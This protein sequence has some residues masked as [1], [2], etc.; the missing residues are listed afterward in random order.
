MYGPA[1]I[2]HRSDGLK[3][4]HSLK[5][6]YMA[7]I[8]LAALMSS[9]SWQ[10]MAQTVTFGAPITVL[11]GETLPEDSPFRDPNI[12]YL[13]ADKI[14]DQRD[15]GI[16]T[17]NGDV[18]ARYQTR[19]LKASELI[20][21][22]AEQRVIAL[23]NVTLTDL[24]GNTQFAEKIELT[25][26]LES[27]AAKGF[28]AQFPEGGVASA[29]YAIRR[30]DGMLSL[31]NA[32]YSPCPICE[33]SDPRDIPTLQVKAAQVTQDTEDQMIHYKDAVIEF[34]GL[35]IFYSPYLAHPDPTSERRSGL[36]FPY[37]GASRRFG[38]FYQQPYYFNLSD[39]SGLTVTPRVM[40]QVNPLVE[41][42]Y[43]RRFFSGD[44][45]LQGSLTYEDWFDGDGNTFGPD[46]VFADLNEDL[47]G[48][49]LRGHIF[50]RGDFALGSTWRWGFGAEEVSDD[51][52]LERYNIDTDDTAYGLFQSGARRLTTQIYAAGQGDDF[53]YTVGAY[54]S[55][56]LRTT[57]TRDDDDPNLILVERETDD[58]LAQVLPKVTLDHYLTDPLL[59]GRLHAFGDVTALSRNIG[60]DYSRVTAGLNYSKSLI[61]P[62]G[63]ELRPYAMLRADYY[64]L[65]FDGE[66]AVER[67]FTRNLGH[68]GIEARWPFIRAGETVN[69]TIEP[70]LM[71]NQSFGDDR[72]EEFFFTDEN[73]TQNAREDGFGLDLDRA[74]LWR[75]NKAGGYDLWQ[76]GFRAD[77]GVS[78]S[79]D[80]QQ[81]RASIFL[82]QSF[83]DIEDDELSDN[84]FTTASGLRNDESDYV[85]EIDLDLFGRLSSNT[86]FRYDDGDDKLQRIDSNFSYRGDA[87][88]VS[89]RYYKLDDTAIFLDGLENDIPLEELSG[90]INYKITDSWS[91]AYTGFRDLDESTTRREEIG[92]AYQDDCAQIEIFYERDR[93]RGLSGSSEGFGIR[94][95]LL[96]FGGINQ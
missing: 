28:Y 81:N 95:N 56:S 93:R 17:A 89:G 91:L 54:D 80:W 21:N 45:E 32:Y 16:I 46:D 96:A 90:R 3:N 39:Y 76:E 74:L 68:V 94:L 18:T 37:G 27:G 60:T 29:A 92:V 30:N 7:R 13:E 26:K 78:F 48:E 23:G 65:E 73:G 10:S 69:M 31:Y 86:R 44:L 63:I 53:R 11:P 40:T 33:D 50:A 9:L 2:R 79:A 42:L 88:S 71:V 82:G 51:L 59:G 43:E 55:N 36:L 24:E 6:L 66:V 57:V 62:G 77:L 72:S 8:S 34:K 67:D 75:A 15:I 14:N 35:P 38:A 47:S 61:A 83:A 64:D 58:S 49:E 85:G 22:M 70:R 52:Y 87:L 4:G 12:I 41:G 19:T 25:D 84:S 1:K 20:Y 5:R